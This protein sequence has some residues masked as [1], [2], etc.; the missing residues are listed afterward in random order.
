MI[1]IPQ[2]NHSFYYF[3]PT[4]T[5][6]LK[7]TR[8]NKTKILI[9]RYTAIKYSLSSLSFSHL[10]LL[11]G[12]C[13]FYMTFACA[14]VLVHDSSSTLYALTV[15]SWWLVDNYMAG[16]GSYKKVIPEGSLV[17]SQGEL[18]FLEV[19]QFDDLLA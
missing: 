7:K 3:F 13:N 4:L 16:K 12:L 18:Q 8:Q 15:T 19:W 14:Q 5:P 1:H 6:L 2:Q 17:T 11:W 9:F 10:Q